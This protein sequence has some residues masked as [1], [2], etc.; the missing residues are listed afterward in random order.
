MIIIMVL[1]T[2]LGT[3]YWIEDL[4]EVPW[5]WSRLFPLQATKRAAPISVPA[6]AGLIELGF[7]SSQ[8]SALSSVQLESIFLSN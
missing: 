4:A 5:K 7:P 2:A 6:F 8:L 1:N 3:R